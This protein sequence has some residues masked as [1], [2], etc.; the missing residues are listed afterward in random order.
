MT[1]NLYSE[2]HAAGL[3]SDGSF[4]RIRQRDL[5]PK[6]FSLH[7]EIKTLLYLGVLSLTSGLGLLIYDNIN[8]LGHQFV[9]ALIALICAGCF[10]YCIKFRQPFSRDRVKAPDHYFDYLLLLACTSLLIFVGYLQYAYQVFG[11]NYGL[12]TFIPMLVLFFVAYYFD[13][14]GILSMA[15]ANLAV[16]MGVSVTPKHLLLN[17]DL[18]SETIIY[19]YLI[20]GLALV[21][22]AMLTQR[23]SFKHH[24]KFSYQHYGLHVTYIALLAGYFH[25]YE[26]PLAAAFML[27]LIA[28]SA[29]MYFEAYRNRSFYFLLIV[30]LY[31]YIAL[32]S[33]MVRLLMLMPDGGGLT[34]ML[35][36]MPA[37][38]FGFVMLLIHLNKKLKQA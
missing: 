36:Y 8:T 32:S 12:A 24:F 28:L 7:W 23:Y 26:S 27:G 20:L 29:T 10:A 37:S 25:F 15:I 17:N 33:L 11:T 30:I 22:G 31:S 3:I 21:A 13:H 9:L 1:E 2:A 34:L 5:Q 38:G 4:E 16:W 14:L 6:L 35:L 19:T 18:D